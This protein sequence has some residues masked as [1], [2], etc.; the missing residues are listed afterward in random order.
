MPA[1]GGGAARCLWAARWAVALLCG[2]AW[3]WAAIR[4]ALHPGRAGPVEGAVLAGG[5]GLSLLPVHCV[6][7]SGA[8][9]PGRHGPR[10]PQIPGGRGPG[11]QRG[12]Q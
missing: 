1:G 5:W 11:W 6:P 2:A 8:G 12:H 7:Q 10:A 3:W 9:R 4:L